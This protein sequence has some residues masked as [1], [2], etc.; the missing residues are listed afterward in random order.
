MYYLLQFPSIQFVIEVMSWRKLSQLSQ[1]LYPYRKVEL[2]ID[3][4]KQSRSYDVIN[5]CP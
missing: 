3:I 5:F 1:D 2:K 4:F